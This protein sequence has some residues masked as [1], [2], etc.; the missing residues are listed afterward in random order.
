V[1]QERGAPDATGSRSRHPC[2]GVIRPDSTRTLNLDTSLAEELVD[3]STGGRASGR[4]SR[5]AG[6][7]PP[8]E[9]TEVGR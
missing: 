4:R 1:L 5:S 9:L 7:A 6:L 8:S 2:P 3:S